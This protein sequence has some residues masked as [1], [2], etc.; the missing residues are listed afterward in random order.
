MKLSYQ[1]LNEWAQTDLSAA[2]AGEALTLAGLELDDLEAAGPDLDGVVVGQI[3]TAERHPDADRLRVCQVDVGASE[4]LGIVCGAP[5]ARAGLKVAVATVGTRLPGDFKIKK[6]KIRGVTSLGML[7]SGGELGLQDTDGILELGA[8]LPIGQSLKEALALQ[9]SVL[10]IALT[11]N[12]GD[13]FSVRGIARELACVADG[14][15]AA[16]FEPETVAVSLSDSLDVDIAE[17][18]DCSSYAGRIIRGLNRDLAT[19]DWL[20]ERLR[21][22]GLRSINPLVDVTNYV[23]LELGQPM[24]AFDLAKLRGPIRVRRAVAGETL[25]LLNDQD[26][27]LSADELI[28]ADDSGPIALAGA[29]GGLNTAVDDTTVDVFLE[30]ACF[31]PAAVAGTGRRYKLSSDSLQRFERGVDPQLQVF[32]LQRASSL[33]LR[34]AGGQAGPI[35]HR[36]ARAS[37][38]SVT[39]VKVK[40]V[41][42]LLGSEIPAARMSAI[43]QALECKV[44]VPAVGELEVVAPSHRYDLNEEIDY[45]EEIARI[46][47]YDQLP[48][49]ERQ[50]AISLQTSRSADVRPRLRAELTG[51]GYFE[52]F[53]FSFAEPATDAALCAN[54]ELLPVVLDNPMSSALQQMRRS[55]WAS[56]LPVWKH[57]VARQQERIRLFEVG[58]SYGKTPE[59]IEEREIIAG[60]LS[61]L[62]LPEQWTEKKRNVDFYDLK[63]DVQAL[64]GPLSAT[65]EY[66]PE[67]AHPA[68]HPG[69]SSSLLLH[70]KTIGHLGALHPRLIRSLDLPC[71][72]LV[73]S[74]ELTAWQ[75]ASRP[76]VQPLSQ[77]PSSRRDIALLVDQSLASDKLINYVKLNGGELLR[78]V[79]IF[80]VFTGDALPKGFKSIA[81][82]L[83]FQ[84]FSRTLTDEEV[85]QAV[86]QLTL[87]LETTFA[88]QIRE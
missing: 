4:A 86:R 20:R 76:I 72:P 49:R 71:A 67:P 70:G 75:R 2:Q 32:A 16:P 30:S 68:L 10:D 47:G 41:Q 24:H 39:R 63:G 28:I 18:R 84:D 35:V 43:L 6:S 33:L 34:L 85:D 21:R 57:N 26:I 81:L 77:S 37:T 38:N 22:S 40:R 50:I 12:R 48:G 5:N 80:D 60:I 74:I 13:C 19:P 17:G 62:A 45:V 53:S 83:I 7:C 44:S 66:R 87:G 14:Q 59:G 82:G 31:S 78:E 42:E 23:M 9:D 69:R 36:V 73:F 54:P 11:P 79:R 61:G 27:E 58:R 29:M 64:L 88:A 3:L 56:L 8:E 65:V 52:A 55:L 46:H 15:F 1:W 25:K 51:R